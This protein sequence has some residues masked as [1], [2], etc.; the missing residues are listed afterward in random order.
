MADFKLK[1]SDGNARVYDWPEVIGD[2]EELYP[3][4]EERDAVRAGF[5]AL[6]YKQ[7]ESL[8]NQWDEAMRANL[9]EAGIEDFTKLDNY[10]TNQ[11]GYLAEQYGDTDT[12]GEEITGAIGKTYE[13]VADRAR[14]LASPDVAAGLINSMIPSVARGSAGMKVKPADIT[15][16][17]NVFGQDIPTPSGMLNEFADRAQTLGENLQGG[18]VERSRIF[19]PG[20]GRWW[21]E[22]ALPTLG[23][24]FADLGIATTA[25]AA[26]GGTM[27]GP[28]FAL[29]AASQMGGSVLEESKGAYQKQAEE[30]YTA[31]LNAGMQ[32]AEARTLLRGE[33]DEGN[34]KAAAEATVIATVS[35][36][37]N[38][39]LGVG[40]SIQPAVMNKITAAVASKNI[41]QMA[42]KG[43]EGVLGEAVQEVL[44]EVAQD[45][46][47]LGRDIGTFPE[48]W[49]QYKE[50]SI[51]ER[52][53][54]AGLLGGLMGGGVNVAI[55][56]GTM[57]NKSQLNEQL[58]ERGIPRPPQ[59]PV[60]AAVAPEP[61][62]TPES[63]STPTIEAEVSMAGTQQ[64]SLDDW[65]AEI[66]LPPVP[67]GWVERMMAEE[68]ALAAAQAE[69][70]V[71][72]NAVTEPVTVPDAVPITRW[73]HKRGDTV[74]WLNPQGE[75]I[76]G[77]I[78][79]PRGSQQLEVDGVPVT[80]GNWRMFKGVITPKNNTL[81]MQ[82]GDVLFDGQSVFRYLGNGEF[83]QGANVNGEINFDRF[84]P[85]TLDLGMV[86][87]PRMTL[88]DGAAFK[89]QEDAFNSRENPNPKDKF[90]PYLATIG[91]KN[92]QA[93]TV[94]PG[95]AGT[96]V[97]PEATS[98]PGSPA[99]QAQ[100]EGQAS[101]EVAPVAPFNNT[102]PGENDSLSQ[103]RAELVRR[104]RLDRSRTR[105]TEARFTDNQIDTMV[106]LV[107]ASAD[108]IAS[109]TGN[110]RDF[111]LARITF[112]HERVKGDK[113]GA[114]GVY[115]TQ[116]RKLN[117]FAN[118]SP[119]T[120][121]HEWGHFVLR[122]HIYNPDPSLNIL[123][124]DEKRI[125][126]EF[127]Q[128]K[129]GSTKALKAGRPTVEMEEYFANMLER[130]FQQ[131]YYEGNKPAGIPDQI[132]NILK[133][134]GDFVRQ[135]YSKVRYTNIASDLDGSVEEQNV[136]NLLDR[137]FVADQIETLVR[138]GTLP[139]D[140]TLP[141]N[142][143]TE[144]PNLDAMAANFEAQRNS[145]VRSKVATSTY[146]L[147]DRLD[148]E[149]RLSQT[150]EE[151]AAPQRKLRQ[152]MQAKREFDRMLDDGITSY[153]A[154][155][156]D[157]RYQVQTRAETIQKARDFL[158]RMSTAEAI[159]YFMGDPYASAAAPR[160]AI[161][162]DVQMASIMVLAQRLRSDLA[163]LPSL[164]TQGN[165][166]A[167]E[168]MELASLYE[169]FLKYV[170]ETA[171]P[172]A[173]RAVD[174]F[175]ALNETT[176][177]RAR[178]D[179]LLGM[180]G[181]TESRM[182][183]Q[184]E[185]ELGGARFAWIRAYAER[186][187]AG[188]VTKANM[189]RRMRE[190]KLEFQ[191]AFPPSQQAFARGYI[192][193]ASRLFQTLMEDP[194]AN[195][196]E[197]VRQTFGNQYWFSPAL[198]E[199]LTSIMTLADQLP[200]N[201]LARDLIHSEVTALL[202]TEAG[203]PIGSMI[204][205]HF[206][207][208]Y[209]CGPSTVGV[210]LV[211]NL[212][213][214]GSHLGAMMIGGRVR[215][216]DIRNGRSP[217]NPNI[218]YLPQM[219]SSL[220][221]SYG[222]GVNNNGVRRGAAWRNVELALRGFGP[223]S[224]FHQGRF[225]TAEMFRQALRYGTPTG[226]LQNA[227]DIFQRTYSLLTALP[228]RLL[229]VADAVIGS[230]STGLTGTVA[231][232]QAAQWNADRY[233]TRIRQNPANLDPRFNGNIARAKQA[234]F[235]AEYSR[236][237]GYTPAQLQQA[238][239][240]VDQQVTEI[241]NLPALQGTKT[242]R[243]PE[244]VR[245]AL[246]QQ[247][248]ENMRS[249][250]FGSVDNLAPAPD[251]MQIEDE[252]RTADPN[253]SPQDLQLQADQ[254]EALY[255]QQMQEEADGNLNAYQQEQEF[256][257]SLASFSYRPRGLMSNLIDVTE[258][259]TNAVTWRVGRIGEQP[260]RDAQG[261]IVGF[262]GGANVGNLT[263]LS[264]FLP[265][266]RAQALNASLMLQMTP[267]GYLSVFRGG[268]LQARG[269]WS[270]AE[271]TTFQFMTIM[272]S[273]VLAA[274]MLQY[275]DDD[276]PLEPGKWHIIGPMPGRT[277][278]KLL[279][280]RGIKPNT[281][282]RINEDGTVTSENIG[283]I[284]GIFTSPLLTIGAYNSVKWAESEDAPPRNAA[285]YAYDTAVVLM[286]MAFTTGPMGQLSKYTRE[287]LDD[288]VGKK[289]YA[290]QQAIQNLGADGLMFYRRFFNE[291]GAMINAAG[292]A[293]GINWEPDTKKV[294]ALEND[295]HATNAFRAITSDYLLF[296]KSGR[297]M[298]NGYGEPLPE[299]SD[300][301][302]KY[303]STPET[304]PI[305]K[306]I[307]PYGLTLSPMSRFR[308]DIRKGDTKALQELFGDA[309]MERASRLPRHLVGTLTNEELHE[310]S[311]DYYRPLLKTSLEMILKGDP[312]KSYAVQER[313]QKTLEDPA[314][315]LVDNSDQKVQQAAL[316]EYV[317]ETRS[318]VEAAAL[319][320]YLADKNPALD[321]QTVTDYIE[322]MEAAIASDSEP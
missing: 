50:S 151:Q 208:A 307:A 113:R 106:N 253:I 43:G 286:K 163:L 321:S 53:A 28:T 18:T 3:D 6:P 296:D 29:S 19:E 322:D 252:I 260:V 86:N 94:D 182:I 165:I 36:I 154:L 84:D 220:M 250:E 312:Y 158:G 130:M 254:Q 174:I 22:K 156:M 57:L 199:R 290:V 80:S 17:V 60:E 141:S 212:A 49:E 209:L 109:R 314:N 38:S 197:A 257:R 211:G 150:I 124:M 149:G 319:A 79:S 306:L 40:K 128:S 188:E 196:P 249:E 313:V 62:T 88:Y 105:Q 59:S 244:M 66:G 269:Q 302:R 315:N 270:R 255:A 278:S 160:G 97:G 223:G 261:N 119:T 95:P 87:D 292:R 171:S 189:D 123:S 155:A 76:T 294:P 166:T 177:T 276:D 152:P 206:M 67:D 304:T 193:R 10:A 112:G 115:D 65:A 138:N 309:K 99:V 4:P 146:R 279:R 239:A 108:A 54:T 52:Y 58:D 162:A 125:L 116:N 27:A 23:G 48:R 25:G 73:N 219:L 92:E 194:G 204:S 222:A 190:F 100:E 298:L 232:A 44:D 192:N 127:I 172:A 13:G 277:K 183:Q 167:N 55:E 47:R 181:A 178:V 240:I 305:N 137:I 264:I 15:Q 139:P 210:S 132:F 41:G 37:L 271:Q 316:Q 135:V 168:S 147:M 72:P 89:A 203:I 142:V 148:A 131:R 96:R 35:G 285:Q 107:A 83:Y 159:S 216:E 20:N 31:R 300:L 16:S 101:Q 231:A 281:K 295:K 272:G 241:Q 287:L 202:S 187:R 46:G 191:R 293:A 98:D 265:F 205:S 85:I 129:L 242:Q 170:W 273:M 122:E 291:M 225:S 1:I 224:R 176:S 283:N 230:G 21:A 308:T 217:V 236:L 233:E 157:S 70:E 299:E 161:P 284:P 164:V 91:E 45:A 5:E 93:A 280:D 153:S 81:N 114:A 63:P 200:E 75:L 282:Y 32:V 34:E 61:A 110:D 297:D 318:K 214:M 78:T 237:L 288:T 144:P 218:R 267:F 71:I 30:K 64:Q 136:L 303:T 104:A 134:V 195:L 74:S 143:I 221:D 102:P 51:G 245:W 82:M 185:Q 207:A 198:W 103:L 184:A 201:S 235:N 186:F 274:G 320:S 14:F 266:L 256:V 68:A 317:N 262:E 251:R 140:V 179:R 69:P 259:V 7:K 227:Q 56:A 90:G 275:G 9:A 238:R 311:K 246:F 42:L 247:Q 8:F 77:T 126:E 243:N 11:R 289:G 175:N 2:S 173:G 213:I 228:F 258:A 117:L 229:S 145:N 24:L 180:L 12:L 263:P 120:L 39:F 169:K 133:K 118:A 234:F 26:S 310:F 215:P 268:P 111:I 248:L 121:V 33:L 226:A 301:L